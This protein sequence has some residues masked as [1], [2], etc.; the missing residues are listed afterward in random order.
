LSALEGYKISKGKK[1]TEPSHKQ[2]MKELM[3]RFP[4]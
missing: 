1:T 3:R 2:E 4:D